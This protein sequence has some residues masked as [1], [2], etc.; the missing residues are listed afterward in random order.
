MSGYALARL[1]LLFSFKYSG[2]DFPVALVWW[3]ELSG[4]SRD[5]ATGMWIVKREHLG[6]DM[7]YLSVVHVDTFFRTAHLL[8]YFGKDSIP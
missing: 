1:L 8:L 3:Y 4:N 6:D 7:P 5:K 2:E